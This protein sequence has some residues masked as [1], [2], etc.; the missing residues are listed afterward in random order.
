MIAILGAGSMGC[1]W[2]AHLASLAPV[3]L[4]SRH[5]PEGK[6]TFNFTALSGEQQQHSFPLLHPD[7]LD[8]KIATLLVCTKSHQSLGALASITPAISPETK[9]VLFQNGLGSQFEILDAFDEHTIFAAV[10]TEGVNRPRP[11]E[12]VHAGKGET[13][14]GPLSSSAAAKLNGLDTE[15]SSSGLT[16]KTH[17]EVWHMLWKKLAINCAINPF[18]ALFDCPNGQVR[19][20][21]L[22]QS[23]WP[24]LRS[25]LSLLLNAAG[26]PVDAEA[27]E[28][29][30]FA[31]M[32]NTANNISSM[33]QDIRQGKRSEIDDINGFAASF[34]AERNL[35]NRVNALLRERVH[36]LGN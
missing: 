29:Q 31:V 22:F 34:L 10:T 6:L 5:T 26:H 3:F 36:A 19:Q 27:L 12:V 15:L 28:Q 32:D 11:H 1:L 24:E 25:E 4:S 21:H 13:H 20:S 30:I 14:I 8:T 17:D 23:L 33:L 35:P 16:L 2:A 9:I 7:L 18:T